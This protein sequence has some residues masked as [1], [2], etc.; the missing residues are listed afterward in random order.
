MSQRIFVNDNPPEVLVGGLFHRVMVFFHQPTEWP[1][2]ILFTVILTLAAVT[3][4]VWALL[5]ASARLALGVTALQLLFFVGDTAVLQALPR[6]GISFGSWRAQFFPLALPRAVATVLVAFAGVWLS[7]VWVLGL[8]VAVQAVG[9]V[10]LIW[11]AMVEPAR[12]TMTRLSVNSD[13]LPSGTPPVRLLHI[14]DLHIERLGRREAEILRL[15][16]H[17][18]PDLIVITGDYV[19][20]S[21]NQDREAYRQ[22]RHFLQQLSAPYG[23]YATLGTPPVDLRE[24]V[25]PMLEGL[26]ITLLRETAQPVNLGKGRKL[27]LLGLDCTH[28]LPLDGARLRRVARSAPNG[29]PQVLLYHSPELMPQA[30][31]H[32]IDLY[33]CGHT[34]GGQ[35]R[36]PLLGPVLTS[37]QLGRRYVM[38]LYRNGRTHLYVSRGVGL[39]GL[40]APRVRLLAPPEVTLVTIH[41]A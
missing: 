5:G 39:E 32:G 13:R 20:T 14:S 9:T 36:L 18:Q 34:H 24:W 19:S 12:L 30:S 37:S 27:V 22:I 35:V 31:E 33:L 16:E 15:V 29:A 10:V 41:P 8:M 23:V 6:R 4:G 1:R 21:Y 40:S 11:S 2:L 3:G 38:G 7:W 28:D 25:I 17:A 26:P